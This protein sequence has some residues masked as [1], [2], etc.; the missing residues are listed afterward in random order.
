MRKVSCFISTKRVELLQ[1]AR[2]TTRV[3]FFLWGRGWVVDLKASNVFVFHRQKQALLALDVAFHD[4]PHLEAG[5][6][7]MPSVKK[8][9]KPITVDSKLQSQH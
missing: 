7:R 1:A 5:Y 9:N 4:H 8:K 2:G 6:K 3:H